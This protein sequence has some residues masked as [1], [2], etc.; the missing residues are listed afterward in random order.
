LI[1]ISLFMGQLSSLATAAIRRSLSSFSSAHS[2]SMC[3]V[4]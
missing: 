3:S 2:N 4:V 1:S